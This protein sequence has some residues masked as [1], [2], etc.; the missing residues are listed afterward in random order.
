MRRPQIKYIADPGMHSIPAVTVHPN[1]KWL[2]GQSLD[3]QVPSHRPHCAGT[4][5]HP[6]RARASQRKAAC[7]PLLVLQRVVMS[8]SP[9]QHTSDGRLKW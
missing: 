2:C 1:G 7:L 6:L 4:R 3:N 8:P 5:K 9:E